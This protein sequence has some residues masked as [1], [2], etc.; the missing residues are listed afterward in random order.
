MKLQ[1]GVATLSKD[2]EAAPKA[3]DPGGAGQQG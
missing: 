3:A 1:A 2:T